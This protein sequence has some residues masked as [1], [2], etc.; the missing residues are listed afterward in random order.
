MDR[1]YKGLTIYS[2]AQIGGEMVSL[3]AVVILSKLR[4][5]ILLANVGERHCKSNFLSGEGYSFEKSCT[6]TVVTKISLAESVIK[7]R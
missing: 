6:G 3:I 5:E 4:F 2:G 1:C 7:E